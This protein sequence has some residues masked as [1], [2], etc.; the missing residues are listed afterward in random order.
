MDKDEAVALVHRMAE[1]AHTALAKLMDM[2]DDPAVDDR[3]KLK[4]T[5]TL[6]AFAREDHDHGN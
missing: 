1:V 5:A 3:V 2:L 6:L 4:I